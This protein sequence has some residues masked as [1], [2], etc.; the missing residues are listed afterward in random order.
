MS[1][2]RRVQDAYTDS[3]GRRGNV[4]TYQCLGVLEIY[5]SS[6]S[7]PMLH[8]HPMNYPLQLALVADMQNK[9][10]GELP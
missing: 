8:H 6:S 9:L 10:V 4:G 2:D 7:R 1:L 5:L 3:Y